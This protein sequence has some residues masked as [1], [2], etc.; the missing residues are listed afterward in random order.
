MS[1]NFSE[2]MYVMSHAPVD[3]V[4]LDRKLIFM[5]GFWYSVEKGNLSDRVFTKENFH[6]AIKWLV[7]PFWIK[8]NKHPYK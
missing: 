2:F 5:N 4:C 7:D 6:E 1:D 8:E 3:L